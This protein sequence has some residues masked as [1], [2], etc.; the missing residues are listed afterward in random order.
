MDETGPEVGEVQH[1]LGVR[2][3]DCAGKVLYVHVTLPKSKG[4]ACVLSAS[5]AGVL[6]D[7]SVCAC[8]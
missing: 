2:V 1:Q 6:C 8:A 3:E 7:T 4:C 5:G